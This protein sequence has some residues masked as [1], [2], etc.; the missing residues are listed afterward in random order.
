MTTML[1]L[2]PKRCT[3]PI[4]AFK[5]WLIKFSQE[6]EI[7]NS[8]LYRLRMVPALRCWVTKPELFPWTMI[9]GRTCPPRRMS[10]EGHSLVLKEVCLPHAPT[11]LQKWNKR[12]FTKQ[13]LDLRVV[14]TGAS[15]S[16]LY[17]HLTNCFTAGEGLG[18][19]RS[20]YLWETLYKYSELMTMYYHMIL[21]I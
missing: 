14:L 1:F 21:A 18:A 16:A 9:L 6:S 8:H 13:H 15:A 19:P 12:R 5:I 20:S 4:E 17:K 3:K 2:C 10:S 11:S 7:D